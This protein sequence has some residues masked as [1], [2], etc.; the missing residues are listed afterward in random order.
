MRR[1]AGLHTGIG[2]RCGPARA[3]HQ[4][5]KTVTGKNLPPEPQVWRTALA[6]SQSMPRV[7]RRHRPRFRLVQVRAWR[8][9][10][11][12]QRWQRWQG[13]P[14]LGMSLPRAARVGH[15]LPELPRAARVATRC[16]R[17]M[18]AQRT[19]PGSRATIVART[20]SGPPDGQWFVHARIG[21]AKESATQAIWAWHFC[22]KLTIR[23]C[24]ASTKKRCHATPGKCAR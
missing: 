19:L 10:S 22:N 16:Q 6:V 14:L 21:A 9:G 17:G 23:Q 24:P 11:G 13:T 8:A 7:A 4:S 5:L 18:S 3:A 1:D 15:A 12:W 20:R 2:E